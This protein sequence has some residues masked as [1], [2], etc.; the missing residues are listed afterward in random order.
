MDVFDLL[1]NAG[2]VTMALAV[3]L[4][5][6][7]GQFPKKRGHYTLPG[8]NYPFKLVCARY[9][10]RRWKKRRSRVGARAVI[11]AAPRKHAAGGWE[12][13]TVRA[14]APDGTAL[15][16]VLRRLAGR[17]PLAEVH[18]RIQL[19]DG[20]SYESPNATVRTCRRSQ[21]Q[22]PRSIGV[23][24][25]EGWSAGGLKLE[26]LDELRMRVIYNGMLARS[27]PS[28]SDREV[29]RHV[30]INLIWCA[31]SHAVRHP[32]DWNDELAARA[33]A[34]ETWSNGNWIG[35]IDRWGDDACWQWG[36]VQGRLQEYDPAGQV[37]KSARVRARGVR[38][39]YWSPHGY[40]GLY[41]TISILCTARDGTAIY[42]YAVS[43]KDCLTQ[44]ISGCVRF[45]NGRIETISSTD[46]NMIDLCEQRD[47][48]PSNYTINVSAGG[49][50]FKLVLKIGSGGKAT[51][52]YYEYVYRML[53]GNINGDSA[54]GL[55]E[56]GYEAREGT[57]PVLKP[58]PKLRWLSEDAAG[59]IG[60]CIPFEATA[61]ACPQLVGGK[62]ASLALLS[63]A[64]H[65]GYK[66]PPGFCVTVKAFKRHLEDNP[67]L[68]KVIKQYS[69][70]T[71]NMSSRIL[72]KNVTSDLKNDVL[73]H[74][75]LL[76]KKV[77]DQKLSTPEEMRFAV[78]SSAVGEDGEILSAA[79]Q[80]ETILGCSTDDDVLLALQKCWGS[81]FAFT[82][83]NYRRLNGQA[84]ECGAGVAIQ[85]L[86]RPRAAG[87]M[88]TRHPDAGDPS[89]ILITANYG[90]GESVVSGTVEP[91]TFIVS[92]DLTGELSVS[93]VQV[94]SKTKLVMPGNHGDVEVV[95][96]PEEERKSTCLFNEEVLRLA[97]LAVVQEELWGAPRDIEWAI[98][99]KDVYLL[100]ARPITSLERWTEEELL[101]EMD[102]AVMSEEDMVT[103]A[104]AGEVMPK[105]L[106]VLSQDIVITPLAR[107]MNSLFG[108]NVNE[109]ESTI[110]ITH[111]RCVINMFNAL[112]WSKSYA[113]DSMRCVREINLDDDPADLLPNLEET[114][115]RV[116]TLCRNH[117]Y[118]STGSSSSQVIAM[119]ILLEGAKD[120]SV[121]QCQEL[122]RLLASGDA[123]SAE[124]PNA[125]AAL[126]RELEGSGRLHEFREQPPEKAM[127]W[128]R[129]NLPHV[130]LDVITFLDKHGYRAVMEFDLSTKP[131]I[132]EPQRLMEVLQTM[133]VR[134]EE[135]SVEK[136]DSLIISSL[137]TPK[138]ASTKKILRWIIPLCGRMVA[139]R[140]STKASLILGV[141][142]I[143]LA[144]KRLS[145]KM[146]E[147]WLLP[148]PDLVFF[149]R[150]HELQTY[151]QDR[152][153]A[154][155]RKAVQR[156][157]YYT[158][159]AQL[160][161]PEIAEGWPEPIPRDAPALT[162]AGARVQATPV[163][164]GDVVARA[165]VV[166]DLSEIGALQQGDVL[167]THCTDIGWSPYFPLLA[168]IVT[169][170]GGLISHGAVIAR[171]YGLPCIVGAVGATTTFRT[172]D[173]IRLS[174]SS[175]V[176]EK[177][178]MTTDAL[179]ENKQ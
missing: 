128:L 145:D 66:V 111:H 2:L 35:M 150:L 129:T 172:G 69:L 43:Y 84:C 97:R 154:L 152:N 38:E 131:W 123:V 51:T 16:V 25:S 124:V 115:K 168:G 7:R 91:D 95:D 133:T 108:K 118:T 98:S 9:A 158:K 1:L 34:T 92:R 177:V 176:I 19:S 119:I 33:I 61:A 81:M 12:S 161:F 144:L 58:A 30:R 14:S 147:Q 31:A 113:K 24:T 73:K 117:A 178:E 10:V 179:G 101:H 153:P 143:R 47:G 104:N 53:L 148:D 17:L 89:R 54:G 121:E 3:Y 46:L 90:L 13:V 106:T 68:G 18:L 42:L 126:G 141:H 156:R 175:G 87:V 130:H 140:E 146:V 169:E 72:K 137:V 5:F 88:F 107:G 57:E 32:D 64:Q 136:N 74:L 157:Q 139:N 79:G 63:R 82:S 27:G 110:A 40:Q 114:L 11:D 96:V 6:V 103:F 76:R 170:L 29:V 60:Y 122:G 100:Q 116:E 21:E 93:S 132:L 45:S 99:N 166:N 159:W 39:N 163:C 70:L 28:L 48:I 4:V 23:W 125:L 171:E 44:A 78:R 109:F 155:L 36:S 112:L 26:L 160:Q 80:N 151:I 135:R 165:C 138:K 149:F 71:R 67:Q 85:A 50:H 83:A 20:T 162:A 22:S 173:L 56:L 86:V 15:C 77:V 8:W 52:Q 37:E 120:F 75:Q 59:E 55:L 174:G 164:A 49:R 102:W 41:R 167:I 142:K 65:T 134:P 105:P 94:G 127:Q 62:C